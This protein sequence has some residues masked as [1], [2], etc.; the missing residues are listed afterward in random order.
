M[1][2]KYN[3]NSKEISAVE[4]EYAKYIINPYGWICKSPTSLKL[5]DSFYDHRIKNQKSID[6]RLIMIK[7]HYEKNFV[8]F[9]DSELKKK[10][11]KQIKNDIDIKLAKLMA[12]KSKIEKKITKEI[13]DVDLNNEIV[14][15][16]DIIVIKDILD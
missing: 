12:K 2:F 5:K 13:N 3:K 15:L 11:L 10:D 4:F 9:K 1:K 16:D 7:N 14:K 6:Q 8:N